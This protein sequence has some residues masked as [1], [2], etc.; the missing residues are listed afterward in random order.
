M[1][2]IFKFIMTNTTTSARILT[3]NKQCSLSSIQLVYVIL[4][5]VAD[6]CDANHD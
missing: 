3:R 1:N 4:I 2:S 6:P 5:T